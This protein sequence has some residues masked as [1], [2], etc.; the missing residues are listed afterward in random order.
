LFLIGKKLTRRC[1]A[2]FG[3]VAHQFTVHIA[4]SLSG[5]MTQS[6]FNEFLSFVRAKFSRDRSAWSSINTQ[7]IVRTSQQLR[8][9]V[10]GSRFS[11]FPWVRPGFGSHW[12]DGCTGL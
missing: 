11:R 4:H 2:Q 12:T 8:L 10:S 7:R 3:D 5:W 1:H 6:V 9:P